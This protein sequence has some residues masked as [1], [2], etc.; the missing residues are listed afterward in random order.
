[1]LL[2]VEEVPSFEQELISYCERQKLVPCEALANLKKVIEEKR[3]FVTLDPEIYGLRAAPLPAPQGGSETLLLID[4]P[5]G[6]QRYT[7]LVSVLDRPLENF[8][9]PCRE[10]VCKR[11][12]N[13]AIALLIMMSKSCGMGLGLR[14]VAS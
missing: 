6:H 4:H 9:W 11:K 2:V 3:K 13:K 1:M 5:N 7:V 8:M 14:E 12:I 10:K